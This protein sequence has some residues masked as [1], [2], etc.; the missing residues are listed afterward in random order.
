[1][2]HYQQTTTLSCPTQALLPHLH[3]QQGPI[4]IEAP[5]R[6]A[7]KIKS[8]CLTFLPAD[9]RRRLFACKEWTRV[10]RSVSPQL[11][12]LKR[13]TCRLPN[14][15]PVALWLYL[16]HTQATQVKEAGDLQCLQSRCQSTTLLF[17]ILGTVVRLKQVKMIQARH[18][19]VPLRHLESL[20]LWSSKV[21]LSAYLLT[22]RGG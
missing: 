21:Q 8:C 9:V 5:R 2:V 14:R 17:Q 15:T 3:M 11:R 18:C 7:H 12:L 20:E 16:S 6:A 1:M 13:S 19:Y 22:V 4:S 10:G